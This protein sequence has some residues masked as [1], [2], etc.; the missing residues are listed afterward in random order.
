MLSQ[1]KMLFHFILEN[2]NHQEKFKKTRL[3]LEC[4]FGCYFFY[5]GSK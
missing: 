5:Q 1:E 3:N 2:K 4:P